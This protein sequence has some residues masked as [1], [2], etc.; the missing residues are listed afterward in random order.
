MC[1]ACVW[2]LTCI[3]FLCCVLYVMWCVCVSACG[4]V[5]VVRP[6]REIC[7]CSISHKKHTYIR[8]SYNKVRKKT[9]V[10]ESCLYSRNECVDCL[11]YA[12]LCTAI[13]ACILPLISSC[14]PVFFSFWTRA[15]PRQLLWTIPSL[16]AAAKAR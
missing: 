15:V 1:G 14:H 12:D 11:F 16:N 6:S 5:R 13:S 2:C 3:V 7:I 9:V 8:R 4:C 10:D